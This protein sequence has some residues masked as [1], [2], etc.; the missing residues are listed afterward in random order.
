MR[1]EIKMPENEAFEKYLTKK[2]E[3]DDF[4]WALDKCNH[5]ELNSQHIQEAHKSGYDSG[6]ALALQTM[7]ELN[8]KNCDIATKEIN[9]LRNHIEYIAEKLRKYES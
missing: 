9:D 1:E 4:E 5:D 6:H 3:V 2:Y 8:N 7:I